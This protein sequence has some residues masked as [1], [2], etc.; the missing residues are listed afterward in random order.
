M[1]TWHWV[2]STPLWT[3][4]IVCSNRRM[5]FL[6]WVPSC[7][8]PPCSPVPGGSR[9]SESTL[10]S[11]S[12]SLEVL[13]G[14]YWTHFISLDLQRVQTHYRPWEM[15]PTLHQP[16][17]TALWGDPLTWS[18][19]PNFNFSSTA[20]AIGWGWRGGERGKVLKQYC[21]DF[22][23]PR[24]RNDVASI[25]AWVKL[26]ANIAI[27]G[28]GSQESQQLATFVLT[29]VFLFLPEEKKNSNFYQSKLSW[30][31]LSAG[32]TLLIWQAPLYDD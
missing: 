17:P 25:L 27:N 2:G 32:R 30:G 12:P 14:S 9:I 13:S 24:G 21:Y 4:G 23:L 7:L 11:H 16:T 15:L 18:I 8:P 19:D 6:E 1:G 26:D 31:A 20:K 22:P 5:S 10:L 3:S 29:P 28:S